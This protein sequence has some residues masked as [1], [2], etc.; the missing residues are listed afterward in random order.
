MARSTSGNENESFA[1]RLK[2][3]TLHNVK[4]MTDMK[5]MNTYYEGLV[6][7]SERPPA[8]GYMLFR[9]SVFQVTFLSEFCFKTHHPAH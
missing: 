5:D 2:G 9:N 1:N 6:I 4:V 7:L 3:I 8:A